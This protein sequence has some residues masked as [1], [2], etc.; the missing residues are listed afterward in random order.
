MCWF[1]GIYSQQENSYNQEIKVA[2]SLISHRW[3][4]KTYS[5]KENYFT[6]YIRLKTDGINY[7]NKNYLE[8]LLYNG[9]IYNTEYL[10][11]KFWLDSANHFDAIVL[12][13]GYQK[14]WVD[15]I[16]HIRWM[17]A[18]AFHSQDKTTLVRDTIW[19]KPLYY[20][21][22]K[23]FFAFA[24]E[25][26]ALIQ[27][28]KDHNTNIV[29]VLPWEII[30]FNHSSL[31][32]SKENF[33]Y[34]NYTGLSWI[35]LIENSIS[36][37]LVKPTIK[38]LKTGKKVAILL[39]WWL[40][41]SVLL[42]SLLQDWDICK[43][44]IIVLSMWL[45]WSSDYKAAKIVE[46]DLQIEIIYLKPLTEMQS[47]KMIEKIVYISES[48]FSRVIKV[49]MFQYVLAEKIREKN[50]DIVI[51]GEWSDEIFYW[52]NRFNTWAKTKNINKYYQSFFEKVFFYTLLQRL[53]RSFSF[54][55][56]ESRVPF[57]DQE[58]VYC[59]QEA[60]I[61]EKLYHWVDKNILR[62]YAEKIWIPISIAFRKKEKMTLGITSK[63]N[64]Y[65][66]NLNWYLENICY[67]YYN[68][69]LSDICMD[70]YKKYFYFQDKNLHSNM[71][72]FL[73]EEDVIN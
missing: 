32:L 27:L 49:A 57:L 47:L 52:Y 2:L 11:K 28:C 71:K 21:V 30:T 9:I 29:E 7:H 43:K 24:S 39:S 72:N 73:K 38:Y 13:K 3:V 58:L 17:F 55:A 54:F 62:K 10:I 50:I 34:K 63:N 45:E 60:D 25:M 70:F 61:E 48:C 5:S 20:T 65:K 35:P 31:T 36:E 44:D 18:F 59:M 37:S 8:N 69:Y 66:K 15:F 64:N 41:S 42:Y 14:Y 26:K 33:N 23:W 46:K 1:V 6:W 22:W 12:E 51:S 68:Q 4:E 56:I 53:D 16:K 19:I 40:D 67:K